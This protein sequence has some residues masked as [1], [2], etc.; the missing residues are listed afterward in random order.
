VSALALSGHSHLH[1]TCPLSGVKQTCV[2]ALHE[3]GSDPKRTSASFPM[4]CSANLHLL[5]RKMVNFEQIRMP[6]GLRVADDYIRDR[7]GNYLS[8]G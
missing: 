5:V 8:G 3:S 6:D 2:A 4:S 1:R 7:G